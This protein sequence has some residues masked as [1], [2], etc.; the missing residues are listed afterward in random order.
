MGGALSLL[1][2]ANVKE[3]SGAICFH[4]SPP[5]SN[6][7]ASNIKIPVQCHFGDKD[8]MKGFSDPEV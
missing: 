2:A 7:N 4:G 1:A 5:L 3:L 8:D 6:L